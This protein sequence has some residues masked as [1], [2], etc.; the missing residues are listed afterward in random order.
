MTKPTLVQFRP[1]PVA[2]ELRAR[3]EP[4]AS[5]GEIARRDLERYY[6]H[7]RLALAGVDFT[8]AEA[9]AICDALNGT[10]H[11]PRTAQ[12]IWA[13]IDDACRLES[14]HEKWG[15]DRESLVRKLRNLPPFACMAVVDAVERFWLDPAADARQR[16][17]EV[18]LVREDRQP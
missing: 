1:G 2:D 9:L 11:E 7:L 14:L 8:E 4:E 5:A 3:L 13:E 16:V 17:R 12:L 10:F 18:G 6:H 15:F